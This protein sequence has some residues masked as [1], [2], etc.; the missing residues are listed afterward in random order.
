MRDTVDGDEEDPMADIEAWEDLCRSTNVGGRIPITFRVEN[1]GSFG[2]RV[3]AAAVNQCCDD[4][5]K[6][7]TLFMSIE[8]SSYKPDVGILYRLAKWAYEHELCELF[9]SNGHR[10]FVPHHDSV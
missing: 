9:R 4:K 7:N 6:E 5:R 10:P 1:R 3:I 2:V 8:V